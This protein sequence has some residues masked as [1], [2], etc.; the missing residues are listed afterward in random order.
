M[1]EVEN[2]LSEMQTLHG[3]MIDSIADVKSYN[4]Q[5]LKL[6]VFKLILMNLS[7]K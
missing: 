3:N 6:K 7:D 5:I 2:L 4:E 1:I